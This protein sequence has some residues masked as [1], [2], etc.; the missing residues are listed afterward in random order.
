MLTILP[1]KTCLEFYI[2]FIV[3]SFPDPDKRIGFIKFYELNMLRINE[4]AAK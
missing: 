2:H 4:N 3:F 1:E